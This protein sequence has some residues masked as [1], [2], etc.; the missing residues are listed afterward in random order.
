[1]FF[2]YGHRNFSHKRVGYSSDF[3]ESCKRPAMIEKWKWWS[4]GTIFYIPLIPFGRKKGWFCVLCGEN[5]EA[6][7]PSKS[8]NVVGALLCGFFAWAGYVVGAEDGFSVGHVLFITFFAA[9]S[10]WC[11][12][13]IIFHKRHSREKSDAIIP[14][15]DTNYCAYCGGGLVK[16]PSIRCESCELDV[17]D[18]SADA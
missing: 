1:M 3:C 15:V 11:I 8:D 9:I 7:Q 6:E 10:A 2:I 12:A 17:I 5:A 14:S 13:S 4:W 16:E 18:R